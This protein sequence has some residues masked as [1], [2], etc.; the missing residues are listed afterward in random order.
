MSKKILSFT[1]GK[2]ACA[3]RTLAK[4]TRACD[5][6]AAENQVCECACVRGKKSSQLTDCKIYLFGLC[7]KHVYSELLLIHSAKNKKGP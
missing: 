3:I 4:R 5:V 1:L 6:R 7:Y 2:G